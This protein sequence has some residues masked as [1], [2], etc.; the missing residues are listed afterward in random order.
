[1]RSGFSTPK[2][3]MVVWQYLL[4]CVNAAII[5]WC[6]SYAVRNH[7]NEPWLKGDSDQEGVEHGDEE[8]V[9]DENKLKY[10]Q[11][12]EKVSTC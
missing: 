2:L 9:V 12:L 11:H 8:D 10:H 7:A 6:C 3:A 4:L 1:M 5:K